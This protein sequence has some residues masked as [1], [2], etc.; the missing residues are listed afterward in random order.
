MEPVAVKNNKLLPIIAVAV[1]AICIGALIVMTLINRSGSGLITVPPVPTAG[2]SVTPTLIPHPTLGSMTMKT[3]DGLTKY[4]VGHPVT[5]VIQADSEGKSIVGY[6]AIMSYDN[7]GFSYG[8]GTSLSQD[9]KLYAYDRKTYVAFSG[10]RSLQSNKLDAWSSFPLIEVVMMPKS[11]GNYTFELSPEGR[12][13][14]KLVDDKAQVVYPK[15][16][17]LHLEIY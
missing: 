8:G 6:D 10:I 12:E 1:M 7:T 13:A 9:F 5:L 2:P 3:K 17:E 16:T 14:S 4:Q 15:T 11:K